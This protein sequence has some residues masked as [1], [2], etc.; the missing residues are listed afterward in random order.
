MVMA[1]PP[2]RDFPGGGGYKYLEVFGPYIAAFIARYAFVPL[3]PGW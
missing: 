3:F 1:S 2:D